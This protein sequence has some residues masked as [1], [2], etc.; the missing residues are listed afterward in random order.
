MKLVRAGTAVKNQLHA[1]A[2]SQGVCRKRKLWSQRGRRELLSLKLLPW[3]SRRR[4]ELLEMLD[5]LEGSVAEL[6][7]AVEAEASQREAAVRL[8]THPG[9]G[10]MTG[11]AFALTLGPVERFPNG[12]RW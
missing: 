6:D 12:R 7:G 3:A 1:L 5:Q 9:L 11:L 4:Q 2:I 10:A 8:M